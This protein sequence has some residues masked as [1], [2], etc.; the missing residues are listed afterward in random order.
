MFEFFGFL[1]D[2]ADAVPIDSG[3]PIGRESAVFPMAPL[4]LLGTDA[5]IASNGR[6]QRNGGEQAMKAAAIRLVLVFA[7]AS[8]IVVG[9]GR[10]AAAAPGA[11]LDVTSLCSDGPLGPVVSVSLSQGGP[12]DFVGGTLVFTLK[13]VGT[14]RVKGAVWYLFEQEQKSDWVPLGKNVILKPGA[15]DHA[16][17]VP[18]AI[19]GGWCLRRPEIHAHRRRRSGSVRGPGSH[20]RRRPPPGDGTVEPAEPADRGQRGG[21]YLRG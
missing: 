2:L 20:V 12:I 14:V 6:C 18:D 9:F 13:N 4:P 19:R 8:A 7:M 16:A 10:G 21:L 3:E 5:V 11:A 1:G 17:A 15:G